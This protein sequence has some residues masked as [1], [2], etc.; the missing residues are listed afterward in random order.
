MRA[1]NPWFHN[2]SHSKVLEHAQT[3][4]S[5]WYLD[6][7]RNSSHRT[8]KQC[9]QILVLSSQLMSTADWWAALPP[10]TPH[11]WAFQ[12][13]ALK[14]HFSPNLFR[15]CQ[16]LL[17]EC[18]TH[19][20][21]AGYMPSVSPSNNVFANSGASSRMSSTTS[22]WSLPSHQVMSLMY[23]IVYTI[24]YVCEVI[25]CHF[26]MLVMRWLWDVHFISSSELRQSLSCRIQL[27][28]FHFTAL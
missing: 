16:D 14:T 15:A 7:N 4:F 10:N 28:V 18:S 25:S 17:Q 23:T 11:T 5:R 3:R 26:W 8:H 6:R 2:V 9:K 24:V 13:H 12:L 1:P 20:S 21:H 19:W 22:G 27:F